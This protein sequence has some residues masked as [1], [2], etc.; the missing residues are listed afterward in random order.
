M[1]CAAALIFM[2]S[3]P[4]S[5]QETLGRLFF[6]P[7]QRAELDR[8]RAAAAANASRPVAAQAQPKAPPPKMMTLNGI[9]RRSDGQTTVWV[10]SKP[11]HERFGDA[12]IR[13]GTIAREGVGINLPASGRQ[14]RLKVG[15]TVDATSGKV[16]ESYEPKSARPQP[17][18]EGPAADGDAKAPATDD[19]E[20]AEAEAKRREAARQ[21]RE[22]LRSEPHVYIE[23]EPQAPAQAPGT[24]V[25]TI[26]TVTNDAPR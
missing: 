20:H 3:L 6:T 15:Q 1:A 23:S 21:R 14:V 11:L 9:V 10:N 17:A 4:A 16:A 18:V 24:T 26:T 22:R 19:A 13:A 8:E 7:A 25:V 5:A 12:E 2:F